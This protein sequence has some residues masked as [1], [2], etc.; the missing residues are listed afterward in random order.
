MKRLLFSR[1]FAGLPAVAALILA[2]N[3]GACG[4][5]NGADQKRTTLADLPEAKAPNIAKKV[6]LIDVDRI[7]ASYRKALAAAE[8]PALRQQ[9]KLR[10]ADL[11]MSRS[12][13]AQLDAVTM[14]RFYDQPIALYR[15][16]IAE[17]SAPSAHGST[18]TLAL[19]QL[20]YKL[21]KAYSLDGRMVEAAAV[22]D[23]LAQTDPA[24]PLIPETQFRRAEKAFAEG[25]YS[26]AERHYQSVVAGADSPFKQNARYMQ[27]W[28]QFKQGEYQL[29]LRAFADVLDPLLARAQTPSDLAPLMASLD[30]AQASLANDTL[31][32]MGFSLAYLDGAASIAQLQTDIGPRVYQHLLYEQ[33]GQLYLE[34]KR[35]SDSA[36]TY[37]MYVTRNPAADMA[38]DFSIK[39]IQVYELGNFP[40]QILP[41]KTE[42][43]RRYGITSHY[44]TER[45]GVLNHQA[46][47]YLHDSLQELASYHHAQAQTLK[48]NAKRSNFGARQAAEREAVSAYANAALWYR[49]F[50]QTFPTDAR[51]AEMTFLL[52][53]SL[54]EAEDY[55]QA[56][57][58]YEQVAYHYRHPAKGADAAYA[59]VLAAQQL[60][61]RTQPSMGEVRH[62]WQ[63]KKIHNALRFAQFYPADSRAVRV[64]AQ[65]ATELL[66]QNDP[67]SAV[68][69]AKQVLDWQ[70]Q[71]EGQLR[72]NAWLVL[73]HGQFDL[74]QYAE[75]ETAYWRVLALL[76][77]YAKTPGSPNESQV[78]ERIA[79]SIYQQADAAVI[80]GDKSL[81]I[82]Q[83]LRV[84]EVTPDTEIA[85]TAAYDAATFLI[86]EQRW[87]E[88]EVVLLAFR[89]A[90]PDHA[91]AASLPAKMVAIYQHQGKWQLAANE[92]M[93]MQRLSADPEVKRQSLIMA[94]E[95]YDKSGDHDRAVEQYAHYVKRYPRPFA[96]SLEAQHRLTEL[97]AQRGDQRQ[98]QYWL[99]HLIDTNAAAG[100]TRTERSIYLAA[101]AENEL[102]QPAYRDFVQIPLK[103]PLQNS[104]KRKRAALEKALKAQE[105]V[106]EYGVAEF[107]TQ[108][109]FRIGEIYAQLS[110]DLMDSQRPT[111]LD[112]LEL[113][114]Y[115]I[116]LEEQA[117]PFEEKAI[118]VHAANAQRAWQGHYDQWVKQSFDAL[119]TLL[120][121]RYNKAEARLEVSHE[122]F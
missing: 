92:L 41:A 75:A 121:A 99:Q 71:A 108:A 76:P 36:A 5:M 55:G 42:F 67:H 7:E 16:L 54:Y 118:A 58:A 96:D 32:V 107:T 81:A 112:L 6:A 73:A 48:A 25:D 83:L 37:Q 78:R 56:L 30:P 61:E 40:S 4:V 95:L 10:I 60:L 14:E 101:S 31:R 85:I 104:L 111:G 89:K 39:R 117:Y 9:I 70:P 87:T 57:V 120:P 103:L 38:P 77:D 3:L 28:A 97:Y 47:T 8:D 74:S 17:A 13:Q 65:A 72:F 11:A 27:G 82:S 59:A 80:A 63:Q 35:F 49:E 113:E 93:L 66:E 44:W 21:A 105:R 46:R 79:A 100:V 51:A 34:Q 19:D 33:L 20:R 86:E 84:T 106:L 98:R 29:A 68:A 18:A 22:L 24:S 69:A 2:I 110:R 45:G 122:I 12:E 23:Q 88:A 26:A 116:L 102:A 119:T 64:L 50:V 115:D 62:Q 91:L 109:S 94:A 90:H 52:A 53:E 15:E 1:C 114:Q 43:V